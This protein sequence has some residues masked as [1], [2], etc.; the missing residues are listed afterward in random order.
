MQSTLNEY[1]QAIKT[2]VNALFN[3]SVVSGVS[4]GYF[5]FSVAVFSLLIDYLFRKVVGR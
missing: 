3:M 2:M 5:I 1:Y 4:F